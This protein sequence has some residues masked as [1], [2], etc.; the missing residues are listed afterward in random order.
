MTRKAARQSQRSFSPAGQGEDITNV[1][2]DNQWL[3]V[4]VHRAVPRWRL[5]WRV[6]LTTPRDESQL[7]TEKISQREY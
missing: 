1:N 5:R 4:I 7:H 2:I 3:G 6:G